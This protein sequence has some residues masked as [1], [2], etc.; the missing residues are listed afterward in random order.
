MQHVEYRPTE[1]IK[2]IIW[3]LINNPSICLRDGGTEGPGGGTREQASMTS[4]LTNTV[5]HS[6]RHSYRPKINNQPLKKFLSLALFFDEKKNWK[7][8][9]NF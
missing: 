5:A 4:L 3:V 8:S 9:D 7:D 6:T 2:L 1:L